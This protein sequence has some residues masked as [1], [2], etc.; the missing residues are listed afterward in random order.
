MFV[1]VRDRPPLV[2]RWFLLSLTRCC[3]RVFI[4]PRTIVSFR[5]ETLS[6]CSCSRV[7]DVIE[8]II[9]ADLKV[10]GTNTGEK[11]EIFSVLIILSLVKGTSQNQLVNYP[12]NETEWSVSYLFVCTILTDLIAKWKYCELNA[13]LYLKKN[14]II[15][16][17]LYHTLYRLYLKK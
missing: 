3:V 4:V 17:S 7:L 10:D 9:L 5:G 14:N 2:T 16:I 8:V 13:K 12:C 15:R 6:S 1:P 11:T